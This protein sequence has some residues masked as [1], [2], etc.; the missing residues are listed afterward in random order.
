M[1]NGWLVVCSTVLAWPEVAAVAEAAAAE[2]AVEVVARS[3][4]VG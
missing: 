1:D 2:E 3:S 4:A